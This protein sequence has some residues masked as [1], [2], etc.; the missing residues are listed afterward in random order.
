M[1]DWTEKDA[2][3]S[4]ETIMKNDKMKDKITEVIVAS[5]VNTRDGIGVE[6]Y[7]NNKITVEIFRD[8]TDRSRTVTLFEGGISLEL[9]EKCIEIFKREIPW[10]FIED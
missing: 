2:D 4:G 10:E 5:D 7:I 1:A 9:M 3:S 6:I 8:D